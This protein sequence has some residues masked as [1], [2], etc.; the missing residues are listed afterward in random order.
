MDVCLLQET[1]LRKGD[2]AKFQEIKDRGWEIHSAPR[3]Q[4]I[5]G[6][7][8]VV[9]RADLGVK[10]SVH[11]SFSTFESIEATLG[12]ATELIRLVNIYRPPYSKKAPFTQSQFLAE[13]SGYL[14]DISNKVGKAVVMGDFNFHM[15]RPTEFYPRKLQELLDDSGLLQV[16]PIEPTHTHGGTLDLVI[17]GA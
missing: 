6:G 13:F 12:N 10:A 17:M 5:G 4:R 9:Y 8:A 7:V 2:D 14:E 16:V 11:K 1:Y 3:K 15:E